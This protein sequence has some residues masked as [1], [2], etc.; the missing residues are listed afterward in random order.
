MLDLTC[1]ACCV[2]LLTAAGIHHH[3][4]AQIAEGIIN[5]RQRPLQLAKLHLHI[6]AG[7]RNFARS[8][9]FLRNIFSDDVLKSLGS[10]IMTVAS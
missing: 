9:L 6:H 2:V 4:M 10:H 1:S 8:L 5:P 7:G 3:W